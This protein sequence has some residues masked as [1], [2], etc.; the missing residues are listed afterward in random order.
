MFRPFYALKKQLLIN[1]SFRPIL[2]D[3]QDSNSVFQRLTRNQM[4]SAPILTA[5]GLEGDYR[6]LA[7]FN[8]TVLAGHF[9]QYGVQFITWERVQNRTA[10]HQGHYYGPNTG[11]DSYTAAKRDFATRSGLIPASALFT[12]EQLMEIYR[13]ST[14]ALT[15]AY[16]ITNEQQKCLESIIEQIERSVPDLS[17]RLQK[18]WELSSLENPEDSGM[19]F[20]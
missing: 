6:L 3:I 16:P 17:E 2:N 8:N 10:L 13:S 15:G 5:S 1:R 9:T 12:P 11:T 7:D 20:S 14:E 18:E 19:Q 4:E